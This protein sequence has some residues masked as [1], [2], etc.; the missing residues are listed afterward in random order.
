MSELKNKKQFIL[1]CAG[2]IL[3]EK[4][5][6]RRKRK[7][8]KE[9]LLE[10][11]LHSDIYLVNKLKLTEP[12]DYKCYLRMK[13]EQFQEL[14]SL[15]DPFI[16]KQDTLMR[17]AISSEQRLILTLR[18][19]ATG[20]DYSDLKFSSRISPQA[21]GKIV[22]ETCLAIYNTLKKKYLKF[23]SSESDWKAIANGFKTNWDFEN[24]LGAMDG[25]HV[26]I[27]KPPNSGSYF[28]N[29][30]GTFSVVL[31]AIVNANY[32][33]IYVHE[34]TNGRISD[35]GV[36]R[37]TDFFEKLENHEL[38]IPPPEKLQNSSFVCPYGFIGDEAFS[39]SENIWKPFP[40]SGISKEERIFNYRLSRARRIVENVFGIL[41]LR[42][43]M[44]QRPIKINLE[45]IDAA[46][47]ACCA[48]H[49]F[50]RAHSLDYITQKCVDR[51]DFE[52][53]TLAPGNWR[54][55]DEFL[56]LE[57]QNPRRATNS[58]K[59]IRNKLKDYYNNEGKVSFQN[60]MCGFSEN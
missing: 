9:W 10:R 34:G 51:E 53:G 13:D 25:K 58:A 45:H 2:V 28:Y 40:Q 17:T 44:F 47:L 4:M 26:L 15:V 19:L 23:P 29:Y 3:N 20:N 27:T 38:H 5:E 50:L 39:L 6:K 56:P 42:F 24:C 21:I 31:F 57:T 36:L 22:P 52:S 46:I 11:T 60:K 12:E 35:G 49:N 55:E 43:K 16:K 1:I 14:L 41:C 37:R 7:W 18:F 59:D 30:K 54:Q 8:A 33:F 32:E 48:L